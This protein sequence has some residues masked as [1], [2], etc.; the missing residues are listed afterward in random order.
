MIASL[1]ALAGCPLLDT[2]V[3]GGTLE[4]KV[5][6]GGRP[7]AGKVVS[8]LV[9]NGASFVTAPTATASTD[10]L[11]D[12][13]FAGL[14]AGT[15]KATYVSQAVPDGNNVKRD[16][17]EIGVWR[18]K[19]RDLTASSGVR[20]PPFDVAYNGLIY[21]ATATPYIVAKGLPLPFHWS[22][23]LQ[24]QKYKLIIY[25]NGV[26]REPAFYT[27]NWESLPT[28]LFEKDLNS[29]T[30]SWEV[31]IDAGE[32]GEGRALVRRVDMGPPSN[33]GGSEEPAVP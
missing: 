27:S 26:G 18:T 5:L 8:L 20:M 2:P 16:P 4:G 14:P 15:Y 25:N 13:R 29:G 17:N 7:A 21:P 33:T 31:V 28:A 30:Y 1:L 10:A 6:F 12:Y 11:G 24:A 22:T 19:A 3:A 9:A 23:H 32:A